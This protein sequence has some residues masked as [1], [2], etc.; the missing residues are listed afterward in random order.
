MKKLLALLALAPLALFTIGC[1]AQ[2]PPSQTANATVTWTAPASCT[3]ASP[4]TFVISRAPVTGT[5]CP[6]TTGTAYTPLNQASP[7][8]GTSYVDTT[9]AGVNGCW[10]GQ[11]LQSGLVSGPSNSVGPLAVPAVP[12]APDLA[13]PKVATVLKPVGTAVPIGAVVCLCDDKKPE[14]PV[15][16]AKVN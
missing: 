15:L 2:V 5:T 13:G 11:T 1:P 6:P 8:S 7:S 12:T 4:C 14:P 3:A 16:S 9:A 10:I